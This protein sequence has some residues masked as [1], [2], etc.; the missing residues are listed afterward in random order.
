MRT[1]GV[2]KPERAA[3]KLA[4]EATVAWTEERAE[5]S[6]QPRIRLTARLLDETASY[7]YDPKG[8]SQHIVEAGRRWI[9]HV[10]VTRRLSH[11]GLDWPS[12]LDPDLYGS[13][14]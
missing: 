7:L 8:T 2:H 13:L 6:G 12:R 3:R 10:L 1:V 11:E 4:L 9:T 14:R 5:A